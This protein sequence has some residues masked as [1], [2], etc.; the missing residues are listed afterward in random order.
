VVST[1]WKI[2]DAETVLLMQRFYDALFGGAT[3]SAALRS[4]QTAALR[5]PATADPFFW[6]ALRVT[7]RTAALFE[8]TGRS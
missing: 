8:T 1:L 2:P 4:A 3:L 5:N 7:G 6:A